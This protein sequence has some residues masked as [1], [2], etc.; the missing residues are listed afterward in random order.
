MTKLVINSISNNDQAIYQCFLSNEAGHISASTLIK[1][2]SKSI[3][4]KFVNYLPIYMCYFVGFAPKF[5]QH[6]QNRTIYSDSN[7][8]LSC[9]KVDASPKPKITWTRSSKI[10]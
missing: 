3:I 2:I 5:T 1:I 10:S 7:V 9:G 8:E 6:I 4:Y